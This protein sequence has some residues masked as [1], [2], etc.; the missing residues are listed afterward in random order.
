ASVFLVISKLSLVQVPYFFNWATD[1]L[2]GERQPATW[3]ATILAAPVM[4]VLA[5][6][7]VRIGQLAFNQLRDAL[8]AS[9]GQH[10][11]RQLAYRTFVHIH[12]LSLRFHLERRTGGL[13]R[14][15]ERGVK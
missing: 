15:I 2:T 5:Y 8:F 1:A 7:V 9:V 4:L 13:S 6:N 3:V 10:A 11:V 14:V 12:D